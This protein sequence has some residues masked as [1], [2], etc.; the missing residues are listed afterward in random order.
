MTAAALPAPLERWR[1]IPGY[2]RHEVSS[3]GN[4][5]VLLKAGG[6]RR[7]N[8]YQRGQ[9]LCV[10]IDGSFR[11]VHNLVWLAF[12]SPDEAIP[13]GHSVIVVDVDHPPTPDYLRL[14]PEL[15]SEALITARRIARAAT[16][17]EAVEVPGEAWR[18]IPGL[19]DHEASS[20]GRIRRVNADGSVTMR[21]LSPKP[22]GRLSACLGGRTYQAH[23]L[24]YRAFVDPAPIDQR[25]GVDHL[26]GDVRNNR[27]GNLEKVRQGEFRRRW[28]LRRST[29]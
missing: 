27:P 26:D 16:S 19:G 12:M 21:A 9:S 10:S 17:P 3:L 24:V 28:S 7:I 5:R 4:V 6:H 11:R 20:D 8:R 15:E 13:R 1:P 25:Y 18:P 29:G 23:Y 22:C 2:P 14:V